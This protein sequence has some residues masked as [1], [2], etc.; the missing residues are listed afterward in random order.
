LNVQRFRDLPI[1]R[2]LLVMS[3]ASSAAAVVLAGSGFLTWDIIRF[4]SDLRRDLTAAVSLLAEN[5]GAPLTFRDDRVARD[6]LGVLRYQPRVVAACLYDRSGAVF[7]RYQR[8]AGAECP[9]QPTLAS[10]LGWDAFEFVGPVVVDEKPVGAI[11]VRRDLTDLYERLRVAGVAALC[12]L[13]VATAGALLMTARLQQS[14]AVPLLTLASTAREISTTRDYSLRAHADGHDEVGVVVAAFNEMLDR[15]KEA[16]DRE[17]EASRLKDEFLATLSHELR[18]PLNAVLG[19]TSMLRSGRLDQATQSRALETIERN[20][21]AQVTL[22]GDLLDMS[23][24]VKGQPRLRARTADLAAIVDAAVDVV[25]PSALAKE[26]VIS[27]SVEAR[28]ALTHGDPGRLQQIVWNLLSNAVKFTPP[29][30]TIE[31]RLSRENGHV[32]SVRDTGHGIDPAFQPFVFEP[33]RQGDGTT[34]REFGGLGLG[35]AIV[36]QLVELHGGTVR[37]Q[38]EGVTHGATFEVLLPSVIDR[39]S[40]EMP[41]PELGPQDHTHVSAGLLDGVSVLVVDDNEDARVLLSATLGQYG[42]K[43]TTVSTVRDALASVDRE[44]P[45][46]ILSDIAMPHEDGLELIRQLRARSP[47]NGGRIPAVAV[48][49]YASVSDGLAAEAAGYQAHMA[50]PFEPS[51][52]V[53]LVALLSRWEMTSGGMPPVS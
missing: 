42:A 24:I 11:Y 23:S 17:R 3:V 19:W 21:K 28:P 41:G 26:I 22:I 43:V 32:L 33:F 34:T 48:S 40:E 14:I 6:I 46:I 30:G 16:R 8:T 4:R 2:K 45:T 35:L 12:L 31:V 20:A 47:A 15:I 38:S 5:S 36:K 9:S 39:R 44:P 53:Q 37:M 1:R 18:T 29:R 7:S 51:E 10:R 50:K 49:A 52:V 13:L 25:R 27:L